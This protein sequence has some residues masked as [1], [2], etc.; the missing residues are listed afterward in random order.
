MTLNAMLDIENALEHAVDAYAPNLDNLQNAVNALEDASDA[1][2]KLDESGKLTDS[3]GAC[4]DA[5][6]D[7]LRLFNELLDGYM[8]A[9][10]KLKDAVDALDAINSQVWEYVTTQ[11]KAKIQDNSYCRHEEIER[12]SNEPI[13]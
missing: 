13:K 4:W 9:F 7:K 12:L 10:D 11:A 6:N 5:V 3:D 1:Y 8:D 2:Y